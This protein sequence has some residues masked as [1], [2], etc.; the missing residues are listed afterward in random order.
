VPSNGLDHE[1]HECTLTYN[2]STLHLTIILLSTSF[3]QSTLNPSGFPIKML[4]V[5]LIS[6]R[7][8]T[9]Y[10]TNF[11]L[12]DITYPLK[13]ISCFNCFDD[14]EL[15]ILPKLCFLVLY[16]SPSNQRLFVKQHQSI[17]LMVAIRCIFKVRTEFF[18]T[19]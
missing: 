8:V 2:M 9:C 15:P 4:Y 17:D 10:R 18:Y 11:T 13:I 12:Q 6:T 19:V 7:G 14:Q 16:D 3:L 1:P 5:F